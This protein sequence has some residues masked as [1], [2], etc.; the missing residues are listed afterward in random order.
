M[1][2]IIVHKGDYITYKL[3]ERIVTE[4]IDIIYQ[5]QKGVNILNSDIQSIQRISGYIESNPINL[6]ESLT[7]L[8]GVEIYN[9]NNII[10]NDKVGYF[11]KCRLS[12]SDD[13]IWG[14]TDIDDEIDSIVAYLLAYNLRKLKHIRFPSDDTIILSFGKDVVDCEKIISNFNYNCVRVN[15]YRKIDDKLISRIIHSGYRQMNTTISISSTIP[16]GFI[17]IIR[18]VLSGWV[19]KRTINKFNVHRCIPFGVFNAKKL[20]QQSF[21][22]GLSDYIYDVTVGRGK[23][24]EYIFDL[25]LRAYGKEFI[26]TYR[27]VLEHL[28]ISYNAFVDMSENS[29]AMDYYANSKFAGI[30][31]NFASQDIQE[32]SLRR[33]SAKTRQCYLIEARNMIGVNGYKFIHK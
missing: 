14:K 22:N 28:L 1:Y 23:C 10:L 3:G 6:Q 17:S 8:N 2:K 24:N 5:K 29:I 32:V 19:G 26:I 31:K 13:I 33:G 30:Y 25:F 11:K 21:I 18:E 27:L 12:N 4:P 20:V 16:N 15:R 9:D 7:F